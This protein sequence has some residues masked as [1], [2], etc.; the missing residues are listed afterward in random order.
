[1]NEKIVTIENKILELTQ[2]IN[3]FKTENKLLNQKE[4]RKIYNK[5]YY[6]QMKYKLNLT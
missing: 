2:L 3:N 4:K 6:K 5:Q 1:M